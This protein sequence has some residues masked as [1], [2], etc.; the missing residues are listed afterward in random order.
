[1]TELSD[2]DRELRA[3]LP[4]NWM[5]ILAAGIRPAALPGRTFHKEAGM[6]EDRDLWILCGDEEMRI[7][8]EILR[9][10]GEI[11]MHW[12]SPRMPVLACP[13]CGRRRDP[14]DSFFALGDFLPNSP[15]CH[16]S[17]PRL[18]TSGLANEK[19]AEMWEAEQFEPLLP[20]RS[21][22][23]GWGRQDWIFFH[24]ALRQILSWIWGNKWAHEHELLG[25]KRFELRELQH[26]VWN[27]AVCWSY[28]GSDEPDWSAW[29]QIPDE[30]WEV[31]MRKYGGELE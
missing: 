24:S 2:R 27:R 3:K 11:A 1:M 9:K 7:A 28:S 26:P 29:Y 8:A 16:H 13:R 15:L 10:V 18:L 20:I 19:W 25:W 21:P 30:I 4:K 6:F 22:P 23:P 31:I 12:T 17:W 14:E 5:E